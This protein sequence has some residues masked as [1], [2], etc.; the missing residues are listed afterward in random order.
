MESKEEIRIKFYIRV[1]ISS[2]ERMFVIRI[3]GHVQGQIMIIFSSIFLKI[4]I[5]IDYLIRV[6]LFICTFF[7]LD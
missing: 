1:K 6:C 2:L 4:H 3:E 7:L 5:F